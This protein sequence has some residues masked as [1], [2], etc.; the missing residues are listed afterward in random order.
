MRKKKITP[1]LW[2][3]NLLIRCIRDCGIGDEEELQNLITKIT[4][5]EK[6]NHLQ[7]IDQEKSSSYQV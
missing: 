4:D 1:D 2:N 6:C 3:Y 7:I 5:G